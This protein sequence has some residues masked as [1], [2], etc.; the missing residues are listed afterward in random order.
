MR[1][2]LC[3]IT[4]I[5]KDLTFLTMS[6]IL[7]Y[8]IIICFSELGI[9]LSNYIDLFI[10]F[11][12]AIVLIFLNMIYKDNH[13]KHNLF[14]NFASF[15]CFVT[16]IFIALRAKF[17]TSMVLY[18]QQ[19]INFNWYYFSQNQFL[20]EIILYCLAISNLL[21]FIDYKKN[22]KMIEKEIL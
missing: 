8:E 9:G 17:D 1:K 5:L 10:P 11:I 3:K 22:K 14:F 19:G 7:L 6:I 12:S 13:M 20:I 15:V 4:Q 2:I 18:Y 16:I 21:F